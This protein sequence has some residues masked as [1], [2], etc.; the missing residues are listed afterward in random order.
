MLRNHNDL[1]YCDGFID[2]SNYI[3]AFGRAN[4][5]IKGKNA[6]L[7]RQIVEYCAQSAHVNNWFEPI[8]VSGDTFSEDRKRVIQR[9]TDKEEL[10]DYIIRLSDRKKYQGW[11]NHLHIENM[12]LLLQNCN[13]EQI[14]V[15]I[16][17]KL[18]EVYEKPFKCP[19]Y[20]EQTFNEV[21]EKYLT[22]K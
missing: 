20:Y 9:F 2:F 22:E 1:K 15:L 12:R 14:R 11:Y 5:E 21:R 3:S 13:D 4:Q 16:I 10:A 8:F 18:K 19:P 17:E 6:K 7:R